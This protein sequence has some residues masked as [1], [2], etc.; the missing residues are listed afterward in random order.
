C[1]RHCAERRRRRSR[2]I[3]ARRLPATV[4]RR[5]GRIATNASFCHR[6]SR[7]ILKHLARDR[8]FSVDANTAPPAR[9]RPR[10]LLAIPAQACFSTSAAL[11]PPNP[12]ELD[13]AVRGTTLRPWLGT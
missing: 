3:F 4:R 6:Q 11:M 10:T 5:D 9:Q 13:N 2:G 7:Q 8:S 12:K 1:A